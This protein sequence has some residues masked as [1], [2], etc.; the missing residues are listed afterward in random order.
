MT[1]ETGGGGGEGI[2]IISQ[3]HSDVKR[4]GGERPCDPFEKVE[5]KEAGVCEMGIK[6]F[7]LWRKKNCVGGRTLRN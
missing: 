3:D 5:K 7:E 6:G 1:R 4:P 2:Y